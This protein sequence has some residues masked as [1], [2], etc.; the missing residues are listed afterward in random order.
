[1]FSIMMENFQPTKELKPI[2]PVITPGIHL[3]SVEGYESAY[4]IKEMADIIILCTTRPLW[5]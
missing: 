1:M 2:M 4:R 3:N 5:M